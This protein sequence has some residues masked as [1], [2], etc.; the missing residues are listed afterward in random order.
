MTSRKASYLLYITLAGG[1]LSAGCDGPQSAL[2]P[3]G[4]AAQR[5]AGLFWWMTGFAAVIWIA[6]IVLALYAVRMPA[7][8]SNRRRTDLLIIGGGAIAPTIAIA[9]LAM[10]GLAPIPSLLAPAPQGSLRITVSGEQWWWRVRYRPAE[11]EAVVLAN[12]IRLPVGEVVEFRLESPDV[13][14]SFWIPPLGGKIDM[15]PGRITRIALTPTKTGVFRG[16]CAEYCGTS[17][18]WMNFTVVVEEKATFDRWLAH[19]RSPAST[20]S[21]PTAAHG[22]ELFLANGCGACHQ[23]RGTPARGVIGPDLTHVGSRL[24]IGAGILQNDAAALQRW[25]ARTEEVKPGVLMPSFGM[26]PEEDLKALAAYMEAL[27]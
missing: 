3:A 21:E 20:P 24:S 13:I 4:E 14:H 11:G 22:R 2:A 8:Q 12:E 17:H 1:F 6:V 7:E 16:V 27:K 5:I 15:I 19:Q 25:I 23:I 10:F 9:V 18:A 26:L